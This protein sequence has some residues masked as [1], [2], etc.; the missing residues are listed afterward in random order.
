[1]KQEIWKPL[2]GYSASGL[3]GKTVLCRMRKVKSSQLYNL[4][5]NVD[6]LEMPMFNEY[7]LLTIPAKFQQFEKWSDPSSLTGTSQGPGSG[8]AANHSKDITFGATE[9][10]ATNG[11]LN[12]DLNF[13]TPGAEL[14]KDDLIQPQAGDVLENNEFYDEVLGSGGDGNMDPTPDDLA[15]AGF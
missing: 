9:G 11:G 10:V 4:G 1:M 6:K 15:G 12:S 2:S 7:F 8:A 5:T 14:I 3:T 13:K